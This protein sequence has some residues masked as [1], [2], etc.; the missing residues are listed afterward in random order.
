MLS[1]FLAL[2]HELHSKAILPSSLHMHDINHITFHDATTS[3]MLTRHL[4]RHIILRIKGT[5]ILECHITCLVLQQ[6][7]CRTSWKIRYH[8]QQL[9]KKIKGFAVVPFIGYSCIIF[10]THLLC[11]FI[12]WVTNFIWLGIRDESLWNYLNHV[13][14]C[15]SFIQ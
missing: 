13:T 15:S 10:L 5:W 1:V 8:V 6:L 11:Q 12:L 9:G 3:P 4:K 2:W 7:G 14:T